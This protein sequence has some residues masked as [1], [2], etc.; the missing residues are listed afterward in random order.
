MA[1]EFGPFIVGIDPWQD[2]ANVLMKNAKDWGVENK[3]IGIEVGVPDTNFA[4]GSF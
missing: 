3:I 4:D 2:S 1:K